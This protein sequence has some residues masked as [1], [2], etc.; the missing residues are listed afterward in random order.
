M[1]QASEP[2][3]NTPSAAS[4]TLLRPRRSPKRAVDLHDGRRGEQIADR[5]P[6]VVTQ[7]AQ[8]PAIAGVA[9]ASRVWS[10]AA[11]NIGR[12]TAAKD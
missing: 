6:R 5:D 10:T 1:P 3:V 2:S 9:V 11:M 8:R 7:A 12:K 4:N